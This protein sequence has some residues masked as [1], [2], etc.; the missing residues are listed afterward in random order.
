MTDR[1]TAPYLINFTQSN[2]S[3]KEGDFFRSQGGLTE[4]WGTN[5]HPVQAESLAEARDIAIRRRREAFP[6]CHRTM[7]QD[8]SLEALPGDPPS[9]DRR[10]F[11]HRLRQTGCE[12]EDQ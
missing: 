9:Y 6:Y 5:W 3:V 2:T 10:P 11:L 4:Q 1:E 12:V 8:G 7:R